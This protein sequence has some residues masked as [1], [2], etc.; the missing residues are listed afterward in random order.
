MKRFIQSYAVAAIIVAIYA[1]IKLPVLRLDFLSFIS[2]F[3][4]ILW[5]SW[6]IRYDAR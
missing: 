4:N 3:N 2:S 1:F 6:D 5:D